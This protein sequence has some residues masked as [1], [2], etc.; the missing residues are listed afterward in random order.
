MQCFFATPDDGL[1]YYTFGEQ[2]GHSS[3]ESRGPLGVAISC[4]LSRTAST[5]RRKGARNREPIPLSRDTLLTLFSY[6][7][8]SPKTESCTSPRAARDDHQQSI[9]IFEPELI[10][11]RQGKATGNRRFFLLRTVFQNGPRRQGFAAPRQYHAP[12]T[13]PGRSKL[14][15]L[16]RKSAKGKNLSRLGA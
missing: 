15:R 5:E 1:R 6:L 12:L 13:A 14:P 8:E 9:G 2:T 4:C 10:K 11:L 3:T 16:R 7:G